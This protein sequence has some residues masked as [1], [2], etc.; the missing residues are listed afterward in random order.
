MQVM[1]CDHCGTLIDSDHYDA[2][3]T[4]YKYDKNNGY[5][6]SLNYQPMYLCEK[7]TKEFQQNFTQ[8]QLREKLYNLKFLDVKKKGE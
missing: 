1:F 3:L 4:L 6:G 8:H 2:K 7:C 5:V